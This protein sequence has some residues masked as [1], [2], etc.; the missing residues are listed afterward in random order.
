MYGRSR[1]I[2]ILSPFDRE[3]RRTFIN[4]LARVMRNPKR[5][6][7]KLWNQTLIVMQPHDILESGE[8]DLCD[9]CPNKTYWEGRLVSEC[10]MEEY[11]HYGRLLTTV[12]KKCA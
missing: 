9:G 8:Q 4:Y 2:G 6:F 12:R 7:R 10:R 11:K 3:L 5:L 1:L